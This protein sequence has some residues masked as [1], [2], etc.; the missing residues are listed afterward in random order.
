VKPK[1]N[2]KMADI[3]SPLKNDLMFSSIMEENEE[4]TKGILSGK[5]GLHLAHHQSD[6]QEIYFP[7]DNKK[8]YRAQ[9]GRLLCNDLQQWVLLCEEIRDTHCLTETP[10][11]LFIMKKK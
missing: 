3:I 1:I 2:R 7:G 6:L 8:I 4:D 9:D 5:K 11:I 10:H